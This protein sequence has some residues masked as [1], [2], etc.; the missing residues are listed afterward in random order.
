M[1]AK[2]RLVCATREPEERFHTHTAL[3]RSLAVLPYPFVEVRLFASNSVGLSKLYN[4]ALRE[5]AGDPAIL[6]FL[7]DD[8]YIHDL[9]WP[10]HL[11]DALRLFDIVGLAGNKRRVPAQPSW[12]FIDDQWTPDDWANLSGVVAHGRQWPPSKISYYGPPNQA[13]KLLDGLLIAGPSETFLAHGITFDE[14]FE[15]HFY[16]LDLC[17]QLELKGRRMGT[18]GISVMHESPG[19]FR[20]A[21]WS[22]AYADYLGKWQS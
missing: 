13:V 9:Y 14:R 2:F 6:V 15:F 4:I 21:K 5:A 20:S 3:G 12:C 22:A 18:C 8:L 1:S 19:N 7:H 11:F 16:D 10:Y 17:R